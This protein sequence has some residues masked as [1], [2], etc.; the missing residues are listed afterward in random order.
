MIKMLQKS[1]QQ[2]IRN[3]Y[4]YHSLSQFPF[5]VFAV[6]TFIHKFF[7]CFSLMFA[8]YSHQISL[9]TV[10]CLRFVLRS[11]TARPRTATLCIIPWL[12]DQDQGRELAPAWINIWGTLKPHHPTVWWAT[13]A[14]RPQKVSQSIFYIS[15]NLTAAIDLDLRIPE[16]LKPKNNAQKEWTEVN[17]WL[18]LLWKY[19]SAVW[20]CSKTAGEW[21]TLN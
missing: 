12:M 10:M 16:R 17:S 20:G 3:H 14:C 21:I 18:A 7:C 19:K 15:I 4:H 11:S 5:W 6:Y 2:C 9:P 8:A 1:A 13:G